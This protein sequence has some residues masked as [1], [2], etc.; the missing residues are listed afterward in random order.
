[1]NTLIHCF[2]LF[3]LQF[4]SQGQVAT[5]GSAFTSNTFLL[6][7]TVVQIDG[8]SLAQLQ[9]NYRMRIRNINTGPWSNYAYYLRCNSE[10][11]TCIPTD[12]PIIIKKVKTD[13]LPKLVLK[14]I[15]MSRIIKCIVI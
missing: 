7:G 5:D 10:C 2:S 13:S 14:K 15:K 6:G 1:M 11:E 4:N 8:L 3:P 9:L 12:P